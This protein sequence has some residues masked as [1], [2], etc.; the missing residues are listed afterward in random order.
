MPNIKSASKRILISKARNA[1]NRASK[2]LIKTNQKKF[3]DAASEG[4]R[5]ATLSAYKTAVKTIDRAAA[6]GLIHKNNA[7]HKKSALTAKLNSITR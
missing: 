4:S 2:S 3:D 7:A 6:R 1:R 5:E